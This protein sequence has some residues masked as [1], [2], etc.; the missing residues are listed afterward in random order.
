MSVSKI[1]DVVFGGLVLGTVGVLTGLLMGIGFLPAALLIG[2][3]L[4]AGVG[5]F[6]GRRFFASIF[7]GTIAGGLVAWR[8]GGVDAMTVGASSGAAMGGFLGVWIS[9]LLDLLQQRKES[10]SAP[11]VEQPSPSS[12]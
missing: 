2:M 5:Y 6:G 11:P 4:G 9:M 10:V 7:V 12:K 3:C 8:L 1:F